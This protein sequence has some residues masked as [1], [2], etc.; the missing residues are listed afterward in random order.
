MVAPLA[1]RYY[2]E[3]VDHS[4]GNW[5]PNY[6]RVSLS[7]VSKCRCNLA[8]LAEYLEQPATLG[9]TQDQSMLI[10]EHMRW[11]D[12]ECIGEKCEGRRPWGLG[13]RGGG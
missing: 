2:D 13:A 9:V 3:D 12:G 1:S 5:W 10:E 4:A 8:C 6:G 7:N 11:F